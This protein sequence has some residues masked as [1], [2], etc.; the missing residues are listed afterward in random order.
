LRGGMGNQSANGHQQNRE[1]LW[2]SPHCL[3]CDTKQGR[4]F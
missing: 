4:L 1:R 2:C 3:G